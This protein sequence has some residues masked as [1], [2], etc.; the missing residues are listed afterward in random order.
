MSG[1][2][3]SEA[4]QLASSLRFRNQPLFVSY[5]RGGTAHR[6]PRNYEMEVRELG[7]LIIRQR[8]VSS[9]G[10]GNARLIADRSGAERVMVRHHRQR[11]DPQMTRK[12]PVHSWRVKRMH[13][14]SAHVLRHYW[15]IWCEVR[16]GCRLTVLCPAA[17]Y[18]RR[19]AYCRSTGAM[20]CSEARLRD[21]WPPERIRFT[22]PFNASKYLMPLFEAQYLHWSPPLS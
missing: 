13:I 1:L 8:V 11:N 17:Q 14:W 19:L 16:R 10:R 5:T 6:P 7:S 18:C 22:P 12:R 4:L 15:R 3:G 21:L 9:K 2:T 20:L